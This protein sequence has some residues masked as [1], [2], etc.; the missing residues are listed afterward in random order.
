MPPL[1]TFCFSSSFCFFSA[2]C[3][4]LVGLALF[5]SALGSFYF[6]LRSASALA[7]F[8][9]SSSRASYRLAQPTFLARLSLVVRALLGSS[10]LLGIRGSTAAF[11][12]SLLRSFSATFLTLV[13]SFE[14]IG[15]VL[16]DLLLLFSRAKGHFRRK[17]QVSFGLPISFPRTRNAIEFPH[18]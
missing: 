18:A 2:S 5:L 10:S 15:I 8:S 14:H 12:A 4:L 9:P 1:G 13:P 3:G 6:F 11:L 17:T 7:S 16:H